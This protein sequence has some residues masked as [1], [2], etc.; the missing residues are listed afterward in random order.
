MIDDA[1]LPF[2][3]VIER[4]LD[5]PGELVDE[6]AGVRSRIYEC[7]VESPVEL[8]VVVNA[9]GT[10]SIGS[11]PPLYRVDTTFRPAYHSLRFTA[12]RVEDDDGR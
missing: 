11:V 4:M 3:G 1:F 8:D 2:Q 5:F 10:V 7:T 6:D 9:D 12:V